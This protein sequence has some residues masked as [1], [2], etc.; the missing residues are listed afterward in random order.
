MKMTYV[1]AGIMRHSRNLFQS[2]CVSI[3]SRGHDALDSDAVAQC[4]EM[5]EGARNGRR[6]ARALTPANRSRSGN[7]LEDDRKMRLRAEAHHGGH[8]GNRQLRIEKEP[9]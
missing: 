4:V 3:V 8:I 2:N 6:L 1:F 5:S 9:L 7:L